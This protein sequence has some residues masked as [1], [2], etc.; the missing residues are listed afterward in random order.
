MHAQLA[1]ARQST[2]TDPTYLVSLEGP[3]SGIAFVHASTSLGPIAA[4]SMAREHIG[5]NWNSVTV[6]ITPATAPDGDVRRAPYVPGQDDT[7][8]AMHKRRL[9]FAAIPVSAEPAKKPSRKM[10]R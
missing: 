5:M 4:R 3:G 6:E 10:S 1:A 8:L 2:K 7:H 9:S